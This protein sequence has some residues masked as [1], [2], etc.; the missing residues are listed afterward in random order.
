MSPYATQQ[1]ANIQ[2]I[3]RNLSMSAA[4]WFGVPFR[5][6]QPTR[7]AIVRTQGGRL[8][9]RAQPSTQSE[10]LGQLANGTRITVTGQ[11]G[12][13]YLIVPQ[14]GGVI[15]SAVL[16]Q[17]PQAYEKPE[18]EKQS[19]VASYQ[20]TKE[21]VDEYIQVDPNSNDKTAGF[22]TFT[23]ALKSTPIGNE[24]LEMMFQN[25]LKTKFLPI[26]LPHF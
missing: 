7:G 22:D 3:A 15:L 17:Q 6:P 13:W 12:S 20:E 26:G 10:V 24:Q 16:E 23:D 4:E 1:Q 8:N 25:Y 18:C 19:N 11:D 5:D 2:P 14:G 9:V 21:E